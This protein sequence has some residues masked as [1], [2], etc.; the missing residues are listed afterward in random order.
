MEGRNAGRQV[1]CA[2]LTLSSVVWTWTWR[3]TSLSQSLLGSSWTELR[4]ISLTDYLWPGAFWLS[5][6]PPVRPYWVPCI[7]DKATA[8]FVHS[9]WLYLACLWSSVF[10]MGPA[11][12]CQ[13]CLSACMCTRLCTSPGLYIFLCLSPLH[14]L[15][16]FIQI[17]SLCSVTTVPVSST[18][19]FLHVGFF[20]PLSC[21]NCQLLRTWKP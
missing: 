6:L 17:Q 8:A 15:S 9:L 14:C 16:S 3:Q 4:P 7:F 21:L 18:L 2:G 19:H 12:A 5:W 1:F 13:V 20:P 11:C 10:V